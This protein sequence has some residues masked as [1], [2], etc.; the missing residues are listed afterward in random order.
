V[1]RYACSDGHDKQVLITTG[2]SLERLNNI[3]KLPVTS[4]TNIKA[5]MTSTI[6]MKF[7][8]EFN[9]STSMT[10]TKI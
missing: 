5:F 3:Q 4:N 9:A 10:G 1:P 7:L 2:K 6:F 8:R